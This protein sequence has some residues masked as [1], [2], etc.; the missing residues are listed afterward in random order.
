MSEIE[1]ARITKADLSMEDHGVLT[2]DLILEGN[3][4]GCVF[5]G[6]VLGHGWLGADEKD[7]KG[8]AAG[9]EAIMQIMNVVGV[10]RFSELQGKYVRVILGSGWGGG[11][12]AIGNIIEN[13]WFDYKKFFAEKEKALDEMSVS[14]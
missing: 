10:S 3:G 5:G 12:S 6:Y 9:T 7:F 11:I 13:K 1:N 14:E 4:W 8:S 2:M